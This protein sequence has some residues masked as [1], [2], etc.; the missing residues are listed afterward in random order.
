MR[1]PNLDFDKRLIAEK[2]ASTAYENTLFWV[3]DTNID[4]EVYV[5]NEGP[6][7]K[8]EVFCSMNGMILV[9]FIIVLHSTFPFQKC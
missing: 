5:L 3:N 4:N 8:V 6:I 9:I 2:V 7:E 1:L